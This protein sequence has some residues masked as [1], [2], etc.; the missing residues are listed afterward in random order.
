METISL[1]VN[2]PSDLLPLLQVSHQEME[3]EVQHWVA[4]D[5]TRQHNVAWVDYTDDELEVEL[6]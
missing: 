1:K 4:M 6:Q 2:I 3:Q 5:I